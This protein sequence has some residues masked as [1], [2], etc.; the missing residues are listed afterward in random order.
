LAEHN[1][2]VRRALRA[3]GGV[4][5]D[6]AGDGFLA[7]FDGPARA[8][9]AGV[10]IREALQPLGL[11]GRVGVHTGAGEHAEGRPRGNPGHAAARVV[12]AAAAGEVLVTQT[13]RDLVEGSGLAFAD[14]GLHE[15][16]GIETPRRLF[17]AR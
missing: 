15:L 5:V 1:E 11:E 3:Y 13:T 14:R 6:T 8:I 7:L 12:A 2:A 10:A 16:K 17:A 4:E 9:R